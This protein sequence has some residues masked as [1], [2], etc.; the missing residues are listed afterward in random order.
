MFRGSKNWSINCWP[1]VSLAFYLLKYMVFMNKI[2]IFNCYVMVFS[3]H[4]ST[5][6]HTLSKVGEHCSVY[7]KLSSTWYFIP[8]AIIWLTFNILLYIFSNEW[9][10]T[11]SP[12]MVHCLWRAL[13]F[14]LHVHLPFSI[15]FSRWFFRENCNLWDNKINYIS[16]NNSFSVFVVVYTVKTQLNYAN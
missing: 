16:L 10:K 11:S 5:V 9:Y 3:K 12:H 2:R 15:T 7:F 13:S 14:F 4:H 6:G 8:C 1:T